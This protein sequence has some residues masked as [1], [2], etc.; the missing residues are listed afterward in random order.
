LSSQEEDIQIS[1]QQKH[2]WIFLI[3]RQS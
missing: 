3:G 2:T 1:K